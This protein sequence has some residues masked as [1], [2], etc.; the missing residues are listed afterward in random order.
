MVNEKNLP[1]VTVLMACYNGARWLPEQLAS[2]QAQTGVDMTV[3]LQDDGSTDGTPDVIGSICRQ[4]PR[5]R[6]GSEK[7]RHFGAIGNFWS[8]LGQT[9]G[10]YTAL[11]D[12]D[13]VWHPD[14]LA[15]LAGAME[16]A[17]KEWGADTPILVHGDCRVVSE[18]GTVLHDS[19]FVHQGWD[20]AAV[21]LPRLLVQ[22]NVTGGCCMMNDALRRLAVTYGDP[23]RMR[24]HDWFLAL[25]GAAFGHV[26]C[27]PETISDYRQHG[28]NVMGASESGL[29]RRAMKAL[30]LREKGKARMALTYTHTEAFRDA[31]GDALPM[32]A[33]QL[34]DDYLATRSMPKLRRIRA[35]RALGCTMQNRVTRMGQILFG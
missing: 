14:H 33:R 6:E 21:T 11:C 2:L 31:C 4:D 17:E 25:L 13:D 16:A 22:N 15:A 12:Q 30:H 34:V 18:D 10:G 24:M 1:R 3:L 26:V 23:A 27:L 7:G 28:T 20:P 9:E 32:E 8:L 29:F 35:A 5:F 19:F